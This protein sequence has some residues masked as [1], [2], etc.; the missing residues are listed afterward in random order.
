[1]EERVKLAQTV[2]RAARERDPLVSNVEDT[3]YA[4]SAGRVAL[5][6]SAGWRREPGR[7]CLWW[8]GIRSTTSRYCKSKASTCY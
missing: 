8:T 5:A 4:D 1:M 6:N 3:V 2:E 7:I